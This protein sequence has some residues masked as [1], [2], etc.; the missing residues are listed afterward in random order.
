MIFDQAA[1]P[2]GS[3]ISRVEGI[4][5]NEPGGVLNVHEPAERDL[6][7]IAQT[8]Q[9]ARLSLGRRQR[10]QQHRR[11][12]GDDGDHHQQLNQGETPTRSASRP[13]ARA[14]ALF[15]GKRLAHS[16]LSLCKFARMGAPP[17]YA[18][19]HMG[20][21][22][23]TQHVHSTLMTQIPRVQTAPQTGPGRTTCRTTAVVGRQKREN[24][25]FTWVFPKP[26]ESCGSP[27]R[28]SFFREKVQLQ[29]RHSRRSGNYC[30]HSLCQ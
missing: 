1:H 21:Q 29:L 15:P 2:E 16:N 4:I 18:K 11:Q 20:R 9:L 7:Q 6:L 17:P 12:N 13:A 8:I 19:W 22:R 25:A 28:Q 5:T 3:V 24:F 30:G 27:V 10:R 26:E 23:M 14:A